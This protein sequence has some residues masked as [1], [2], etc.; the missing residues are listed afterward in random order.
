M[1]RKNKIQIFSNNLIN[2]NF[3]SLNKSFTIRI[4][5]NM[6]KLLLS[7]KL[8]LEAILLESNLDSYLETKLKLLDQIRRIKEKSLLNKSRDHKY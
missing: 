7:F 1:D 2:K 4:F 8:H 5:I 3:R 6:I